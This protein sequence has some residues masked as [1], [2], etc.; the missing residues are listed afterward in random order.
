VN[1]AL[2]RM[3][4]SH[5]ETKSKRTLKILKKTQLYFIYYVGV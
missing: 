4:E 3:R 5:A 2:K 1:T